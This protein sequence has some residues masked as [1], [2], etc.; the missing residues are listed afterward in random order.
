MLQQNQSKS[1]SVYT[2]K[3][4]KKYAYILELQR[5]IVARRLGSGDGLLRRQSFRPNDPRC[6]EVLAE[7]E[8]PLPTAELVR[9]QVNSECVCLPVNTGASQ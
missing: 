8:Q 1:W 9:I 5:D 2:L 4:K 6:L 7:Q 3:E